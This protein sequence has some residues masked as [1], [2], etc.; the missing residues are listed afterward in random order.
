MALAAASAK[1]KPAQDGDVFPP[2]EGVIAVTAVRARGY[3]TFFLRKA[4]E[5]DVQEA[6]EGESE[7]ER[8]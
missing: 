5:E 4:D 6:A 2:G 7:Q 8:E 3:E 1:D